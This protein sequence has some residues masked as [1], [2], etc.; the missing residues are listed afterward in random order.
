MATKTFTY[1]KDED[2]KCIDLTTVQEVSIK[3]YPGSFSNR[4]ALLLRNIEQSQQ[5]LEIT[6]FVQTFNDVGGTEDI[7]LKNIEI[8]IQLLD[9]LNQI[10]FF[11]EDDEYTVFLE[12]MYDYI[13]KGYEKQVEDIENEI[14][15][16]FDNK[17]VLENT[18]EEVRE[19]IDSLL[20]DL[21]HSE[22]S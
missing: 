6:F 18:P 3:T 14:E 8:C 11:S 5:V 10:C 4:T 21:S 1:K 13:E 15:N 22:V 9:R 2:L 7:K 19:D 12:K 20:E 17:K 16:K